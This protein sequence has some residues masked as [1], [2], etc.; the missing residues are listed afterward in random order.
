M[1]GV[2]EAVEAGAAATERQRRLAAI[3]AMTEAGLFRLLLPRSVGGREMAPVRF[4]EVLEELGRADGSSGWCVCQ[5]SV[6][7]MA[8]ALLELQVA[9]TVFGDERAIL[10][11]GFGAPGEAVR[12]EGGWRIS[13]RWAFGSGGH[14]ATWLGG[15]CAAPEP[16]MML[17]PQ[18][19]ARF[20]DDWETVGLRGTGSDSY[21]VEGLFVPEKYCFR[22]GDA[23]HAHAP[24]PLYRMPFDAM[25]G[26]GFASVALGV[27]RGMM[28]ALLALAGDK[29][30]RAGRQRLAETAAVQ[31]AVGHAEGALRAARA[32]LREAVGDA[33]TEAEKG[34]VT[35]EARI[36]VRLA[37]THAFRAARTAAETLYH[38]AGTHAVFASGGFERRMRDMH[39]ISQHVHGREQHAEVVGRW[40]LGLQPELQFL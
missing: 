20:A 21:A 25:W 22:F 7:S 8:A 24:G 38:L 19:A 4:L 3:D 34:E 12:G 32:L 29:T 5:T 40:L 18:S 1:S 6:C 13:G 26:A 2:L 28:D 27:A 9:R 17:F 10:A 39:T 11:W 30:P 33:F 31:S 15:S 23:P 36:G 14:H 37:A 16:R 35:V